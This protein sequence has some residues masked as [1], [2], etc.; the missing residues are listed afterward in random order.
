MEDGTT[1]SA[2]IKR[3][4]DYSMN[5]GQTKAVEFILTNEKAVV[6]EG[7]EAQLKGMYR[8]LDVCTPSRAEQIHNIIG[9][10]LNK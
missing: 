2:T 8:E 3:V 5:N 7:L 9:V 6:M 10:M 4:Y 1:S